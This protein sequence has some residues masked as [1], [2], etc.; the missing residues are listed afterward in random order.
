MTLDIKDVRA[1]MPNYE[2]Y[3]DWVRDGEICGIAVHHSATA[4]QAT[5]APIGD[6]YAFFN[7]HVNVR[8]WSHGGYNYVITGQGQIQYALDE[9]ISAYHAG[10]KDPNNS[11]GLEYGQY[12]N[13]HYLA[14]C[15]S[16]WFEH[17]RT[18]QDSA[19][20]VQPI[21][22]DYTSPTEAQL[23]S[24][25]ALIQQLR[26]KYN[27]PVENVRGHR[28]LAGNSTSCPGVNFDPAELRSQLRALDEAEPPLEPET[29]PTV[30][31]G[32]HVLLLPDADK[33]LEAVLAYVWKFQPDVSF[34]V[35]DARGRWK[36]MTVIGGTDE[37]SET[38]LA[39]L[40]SGGAAIVQRIAGGPQTVQATLDELIA[41]EERFLVATPEPTPDGNGSEPLPEPEPLP[42]EEW[43]TYTVQP[44]DTLSAVAKQMY[45]ASHLWRI[46]FEANR[47][48][49]SDPGR[50]Y[51][52]QTL[53]IPPK[54]EAG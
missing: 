21:P 22:D 43:R 35:D 42:E 53:K 39:R 36:Y 45:G 44:G 51:P 50:I 37:V 23:Q 8:G 32:E 13:N 26:Q 10:F 17:N 41:K 30:N 34:S 4:D 2:N 54:P 20:R 25:L 29:Q 24:L 46:I 9:R 28:E 16:G 1:E 11:Q 27:V 14:I 52:G 48:T 49:V 40:R 7:Y 12:W 18:Y 15:L 19:G 38:Q 47:D 3:K 31:P 6:A 33:Y 5:G